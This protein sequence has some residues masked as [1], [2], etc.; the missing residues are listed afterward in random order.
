MI[1]SPANLASFVARQRE[2][3]DKQ[4]AQLG[5]EARSWYR[6][7]NTADPDEAEVMLYD[8]IGG[9]FGATAD[10]F[11]EDLK[12]VTSPSL[13]VRVNSPGGS[14]FEGIAIANALR[15]HPATVTVQV[16]GIAASIAS[17][18]AMAGDRVVMA[19]QTMMMIHDA[20]GICMGNAADM[21]EMEELLDL[22][23]DNIADAYAARAGGT[24]EQWR[25]RMR[26]ETWYL[27][28]DAVEA[29][30]A[31]ECLPIPKKSGTAPE[32][33]EGE[34]E[35]EMR[36]RFDLSAY[37][38]TGPRRPDTPKPAPGP[39]RAAVPTPETP[40][41]QLV[42]SL[43]DLLGEEAVATLRAAVTAPAEPT[44]TAGAVDTES[45]E[46]AQDGAGDV[47]GP[48]TLGEQATTDPAEPEAPG[49]GWAATV[50][51]LIHPE[52]DPW[53]ALTSHLTNPTASSSAATEAA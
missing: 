45:S 5:I 23:S 4:R 19:P 30:L 8:E 24:R 43:A 42:V 49:D 33:D 13:R 20:A 36:R 35:P 48:S 3:A 1:N 51:H 17:V 29:G 21:A 31:E 12:G 16:D 38:Y 26:A 11:I 7:S 34:E 37:G 39:P 52:P 53:A 40:S 50:A 25:E 15:S 27:P 47:S 44:A 22:I 14:V 46:A 41:P 18:I 2:Q 10:Q 32:P 28:E 9:W 6:I